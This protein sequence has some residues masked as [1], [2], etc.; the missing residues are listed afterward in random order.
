MSRRS[1]EQDEPVDVSFEKI[2]RQTEKAFLVEVDGEETWV[3]K[4]Q[5]EN[6]AE[7]SD[8]LRKPL[9]DRKVDSITVPRWL[10]V[11]NGWADDE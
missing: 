2:L 6:A 5:V 8:D 7:L 1:A 11:Q 9:N 4:S 3:A 10:A